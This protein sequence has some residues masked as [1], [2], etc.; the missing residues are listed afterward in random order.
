MNRKLFFRSVLLLSFLLIVSNVSIIAQYSASNPIIMQMVTAELQKRGL[1]EAEVRARLLQEGIN[2]DTLTPAD[3]PQYQSRIIAILDKMQNEK[4]GVISTTNTTQSLS[5]STNNVSVTTEKL[6]V[7]QSPVEKPKEIIR[8]KSD[9]YGHSVFTDKSLDVTMSTDGAQAPDTYVIGEGDE[10][11]ITIFGASQT[12]IQQRVNAQ[13]SIQPVGTSKLFI[14]GLTLSQA[15]ELIKR[16]LSLSYLF[17]EDQVA[18]SVVK[19]RTIMVNIFG[20]VNASGSINISALNSALNA[21]SVAGGPSEIGSVRN[22]QLIRGNNRKN[23][24]LY[25]FMNDPSKQFDFSL[26]N[27]DIIFVPVAQKIVRVEGAVNR[28]MSYEMLAKENLKDLIYFAGG[29]KKDVYPEFV[30]VER[31]ENGDVKLNEYKLGDVMSGKIKVDM[32]NGDIVRIKNIGKTLDQYVEVE[33]SVYYPGKYDLNA[34][35]TLSTL[36]KNAKP[37]FQAKTDFLFVERL[38]S[39]STVEVLT[40]PFP[41]A[42]VQEYA[43]Q[44]RDKIRVLDQ[45]VYRDMDTISVNGQV[46]KPFARSFG[47]N[48][49]LT[50]NQAIDL[51]GGL[52]STVYP[53]AYIFRKNVFNPSEMKYIQVNLNAAQEIYLQPGDQLNVYD[54]TTYSNVGQLRISGA[55]K[56]PSSYTFD[57]TMSVQDLILNAGGL[58]FGAAFN[59]VEVFRVN[60]SSTEAAQLE[61][62]TLTVDSTYRV[63]A[64]QN[65]H[66]QPF[67]HVVARMT[68]EFTTGRTVELNGEVKY[69]GVYVLENKETQLSDIIKKAGGLLKSADPNGT[70]LFRTFK[71]RG[72]ISVNIT[73]AISHPNSYAQ[74]PIL[75]EGDVVNINRMENTVTIVGKGTGLVNYVIDSIS[76]ENVDS[77]FKSLDR[78]SYP[79]KVVVYR[80]GRLANWYIKKFAGG[81]NKNADRTTV[82]V[83]YP[84]NETRATKHFW[85]FRSYPKV[86]PGSTIELQLSPDKIKAES[87]P[88][89]HMDFETTLSKSLSIM[90][91]TLSI[92]ILV[93]RL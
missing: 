19:V 83:T 45:A 62:I 67:D 46:R 50:V 92:I 20:E 5:D 33:G 26:Q 82:T 59:R 75:F 22:I 53:V 74:N 47:L 54:N 11:H 80:G 10:I 63:V 8:S 90:M 86:V 39:D 28:P 44:A 85:F 52:K 25:A 57:A 79:N 55:V 40:V 32:T 23:I 71:N 73:G 43:L 3:A 65:F 16:Q 88:K 78:Q 34:N 69:P 4:K 93:Q 64:P 36:I 56:N 1:T 9:I 38:R 87:K 27:N 61:L 17:R 58:N 91:S 66:L 60:L 84:N 15:R 51:A 24:D 2:V 14:K 41:T 13:G 31:F 12:D 76:A 81:F 42:N 6:E 21:L 7:E 29:L 89:E 48:D 77:I 37:N 70:T 68:P 18:V 72:T 35:A 49:K 30:Q